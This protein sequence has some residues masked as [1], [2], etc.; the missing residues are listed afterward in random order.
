M[1]AELSKRSNLINDKE[2]VIKYNVWK[3]EVV[4]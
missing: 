4:K 3:P 2:V 1:V